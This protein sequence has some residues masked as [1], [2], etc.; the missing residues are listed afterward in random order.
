MRHVSARVYAIT[1]VI[2]TRDRLTFPQTDPVSR[3]SLPEGRLVCGYLF[4]QL[5]ADQTPEEE[6]IMMEIMPILLICCMSP[7]VSERVV[8]C[9]VV[10]RHEHAGRLEIDKAFDPVPRRELVTIPHWSGSEKP[11][12]TRVRAGSSLG[13][14]SG[15]GGFC[16][17]GSPASSVIRTIRHTTSV[18][19]K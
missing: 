15:Q 6:A 12:V 2:M 18:T 17:S 19:G 16:T 9:Q 10:D 4:G 13:I 1:T 14:V 11:F 8:L 5:N 3:K 7:H